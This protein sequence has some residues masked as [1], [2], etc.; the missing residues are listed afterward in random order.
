MVVRQLNE[1]TVGKISISVWSDTQSPSPAPPFR[2]HHDL[3]IPV[4]SDWVCIGGGGRGRGDPVFSGNFLTAS[5]PMSDWTTWKIMS[6]D[7]I[8]YCTCTL[9]GFAIGMK[10]D[11]LTR[12]ELIANLRHTSTISPVA[13]S[14]PDMTC[15][16]AP[17]FLLLGGGFEVLDQME[18]GGN[19]ATGSFPFSTISWRAKSKDEYIV[20]ES[21]IRVFTIS[22]SPNIRNANGQVIGN[23]ATTFKKYEFPD[24][25]SDPKSVVGPE[26][27]FALCGGG[28][29]ANYDVNQLLW[30]LEPTSIAKPPNADGSDPGPLK[31][32]DRIYK[33]LQQR[34]TLIFIILL[35]AKAELIQ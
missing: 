31:I 12:D 21:R 32:T 24:N 17:G 7:H 15:L 1:I 2:D 10:I 20:T 23:V 26:A 9:T 27:G 14:H 5:F 29:D 3:T 33:H 30:D 4:G 8:T 25:I 13:M 22:I 6:R 34:R 18:G 28:G 19:L 11:G 16:V 35:S